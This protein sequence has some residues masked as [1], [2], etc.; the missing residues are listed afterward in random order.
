MPPPPAIR[1]PLAL[2]IVAS[3]DAWPNT[4]PGPFGDP[5]RPELLM[6]IAPVTSTLLAMPGSASKVTPGPPGTG[7]L[8]SEPRVP[9]LLMTIPPPVALLFQWMPGPPE[10]VARRPPVSTVT[11][12]VP[13]TLTVVVWLSPLPT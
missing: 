3:T 4:M 7:P 13:P 6:V 11:V 9:A 10:L 2:V 8:A 1:P 5:I 12:S